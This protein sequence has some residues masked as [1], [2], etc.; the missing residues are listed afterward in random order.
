M[1]RNIEFFNN[2]VYTGSIVNIDAAPK[3]AKVDI[4]YPRSLVN[5]P[6]QS[7]LL[8]EVLYK[9]W[10]GT[11]VAGWK[12]GVDSELVS[13]LSKFDV[14]AMQETWLIEEDKLV[15]HLCFQGWASLA[16][17]TKNKGWSSGGLCIFIKQE[18]Q[19]QGEKLY[20]EDKL[21]LFY[22]DEI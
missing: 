17:K 11:Y 16:W 14:I 12:E 10:L 8:T 5:Q 3:T 22:S 13:S 18:L 7:I 20:N 15:Q 21:F 4:W 6:S 2:C 19:W 9:L 1:R